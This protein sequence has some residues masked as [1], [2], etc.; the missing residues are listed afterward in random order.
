MF[1][2]IDIFITLNA[3]TI[4]MSILSS[5]C[6]FAEKITNRLIDTTDIAYSSEWCSFPKDIQFG[7]LRVLQMGQRPIYFNCAGIVNCNLESCKKVKYSCF[8]RPKCV[9]CS[10]LKYINFFFLDYEFGRFVLHFSSKCLEP[11]ML[12]GSQQQIIR[13]GC[14]D[15]LDE[16]HLLSEFVTNSS[17]WNTFLSLL[18]FLNVSSVQSKMPMHVKKNGFWLIRMRWIKCFWMSMGNKNH[19]DLNAISGTVSKAIV[20]LSEYNASVNKIPDWIHRQLMLK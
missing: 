1:D 3:L 14:I 10:V 19:F 16:K 13:N 18:T 6:N 4:Q 20:V 7:I 15:Y 17:N 5:Y 12:D 11:W 2:L 9:Y 8:Q